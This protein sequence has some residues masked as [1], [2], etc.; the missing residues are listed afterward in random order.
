MNLGRTI[1]RIRIGDTLV[2]N[3]IGAGNKPTGRTI[4][5]RKSRYIPQKLPRIR[6]K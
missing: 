3:E 5:K 2:L 4:E 1:D 6:V